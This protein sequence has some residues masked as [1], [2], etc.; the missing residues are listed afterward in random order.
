MTSAEARRILLRYRPGFGDAD[1]PEIAEALGLAGRNPE[2]ARW[3]EQHCGFQTV[4]RTR[5]RTIAIPAELKE[6][7][8]AA[9]KIIPRRRW[10]RHPAWLSAAAA[11]V[12][13][14]GLAVFWLPPRAPDRFVNFQNRMVGTVLRE[15]RM[16]VVTND[17]RPVRQFLAGKGAPSDYELTKGLA[18]LQLT[19]GGLLR[20]RS[21]PVSMVCFDRGDRQMLFLFVMKRS[22]VKDPPGE[23]P[24]VARV[25]QLL[26]VTWAR[27]DNAYLLA[28]PEESDFIRKYL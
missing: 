14:A 18:R 13:L 8:L 28:G 27:G 4:M 15:Y 21:N 12:L 1:E 25:N 11:V 20:W 2:L 10:W 23:N 24:Q 26:T 7:L 6:R 9:P 17:M 3:F 19:G 5:F 16:D 22:A